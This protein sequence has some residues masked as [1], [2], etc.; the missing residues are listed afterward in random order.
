MANSSMFGMWKVYSTTGE[1]PPSPI[2]LL[3]PYG[4]ALMFYTEDISTGMV[5][6]FYIYLRLINRA[7]KMV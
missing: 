7:K 3:I 5:A 4:S 1:F 2:G 6:L